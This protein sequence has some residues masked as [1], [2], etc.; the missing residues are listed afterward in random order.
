[1]ENLKKIS[2]VH[3]GQKNCM[4][5]EG[6]VEIVVGELSKRQAASGNNVT[7]INRTSKAIGTKLKNEYW[8]GVKIKYAPTIDKKGLA[9]VTSSFFASISSAFGSYDIV[10]IHAEG[11]NFFSFI[12]K[13]FRKK[14]ISHVHGIDWMRD[15]W[16]GGFGSKFIRQGEKNLVKCADKVIVLNKPQHDY[17]KKNYGIEAVIIPNGIDKLEN[18]SPSLIKTKYNLEKDGYILYL[19]R[20]VPEKR[21]DLLI[22]AYKKVKTN[23]KLVIA[24]GTS[25]TD[26]YVKKLKDLAKNNKNIIFTGHVEGQILSELYSNAYI[27]VLPSDIEGMPISLLEALSYGNCCLTSDIEEITD[28]A[29]PMLTT[30]K[31]GNLNELVAKLEYLIENENV[32]DDFKGKSSKYICEQYNWDET[33]KQIMNLY[34]EVLNVR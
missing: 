23:K 10:H 5:R 21:A 20:L 6:G 30:F 3:F 14:V 11:P 4:S 8:N 32:V 1:M 28:T 16:G 15:K 17:F 2:I 26:I 13:L 12:P 31:K 29:G 24:G 18:V 33:N 25:D 9:A 22:D 34:H 7:C 27:Y 19:S